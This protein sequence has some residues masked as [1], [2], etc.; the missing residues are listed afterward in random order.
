[1]QGKVVDVVI[2]GAGPAGMTAALYLIRGGLDVVMFDPNGYGG[3]MANAPWIENYPGFKGTGFELAEKMW[4]PLE[5]KVELIYEKVEVIEGI[6]ENSYKVVGTDTFVWCNN[7]IIATGGK[8]KT[9]NIPGIDKPHVHYCA[10]CDGPLYINKKVAVIGD[11]NSAI[12]YAMDL[13]NYCSEVHLL[14]IGPILYGEKSWKDKIMQAEAEGKV[15]IHWNFNTVEITDSAVISRLGEKIDVDGVFVAVGYDPVVPKV[16]G[17]YL[18]ISNGYIIT[19][20]TCEAGNDRI[21]AVGDVATKPYRQV[22][23]AVNDGMT[24][25]LSIIKKR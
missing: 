2:I 13:K 14:A 23:S 15:H 7:I 16:E 5:D 6:L 3:Q 25:A 24:A 18:P 19:T 4:E 22:A 11:A 12:Q 10:T 20:P 9:L 21:Y 17:I 1:M 8:P